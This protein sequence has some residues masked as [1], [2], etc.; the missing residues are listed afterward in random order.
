MNGIVESWGR[1]LSGYTPSLSI[2]ITRECPLR[3][4]GCYAYGSEH[5]GGGVTL[6][7]VSDF[8][9]QALIDGI[10]GL[11]ARIG[12]STCRSWAANHWCGSASST[13]CC[14]SCLRWACTCRWSRAPCAR[15]RPSGRG[16]RGCR[17]SCRS[18]GCSRSTTSPG[19]GDLR[20]HPE[21]HRRA[22]DRGALHGD[23]A[24]GRPRRLSP[25]IRCFLVRPTARPE[26]LV[27]PLHA[28][29]R[30]GVGREAP[31]C[32]PAAG[33]QGPVGL[34]VEYPKMRDAERPD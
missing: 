17:S 13:S 21:A 7:E 30:R 14:R 1:I 5:L 9:G 2:E 22:T 29:G 24:T 20:S 31:T 16:F 15:F 33:R 27:Q 28:A 4:P 8:K 18:T 23:A 10:V 32:R 3:C 6:R 34:R 19:A 25:R 11:V 26:D 12:R